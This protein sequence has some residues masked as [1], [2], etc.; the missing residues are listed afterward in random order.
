MSGEQRNYRGWLHV[1]LSETQ[2]AALETLAEHAG[3]NLDIAE[4]YIEFEYQ[5]R[6]TN[7]FVVAFLD[8]MAKIIHHADGEISCEISNDG[9][10]SL[11]EFYRFEEGSLI[12][13]RGRIEREPPE[14]VERP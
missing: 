3:L 12:R 11:F 7:R 4:N 5:G 2:R 9:A 8:A 10:D 1:T 14:P 13:Q 6:D